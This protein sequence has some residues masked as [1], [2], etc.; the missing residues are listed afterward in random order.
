MNK[1]EFAMLEKAFEAEVNGALSRSGLSMI[2]TTS[3]TAEK[4]V[5]DGLLKRADRLI[6]GIHPVQVSGFELTHAGRLLY[7][8]MCD[9]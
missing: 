9:A 1:R 6:G 3:K 5:A 4:L 8:A 2:Q 7:C